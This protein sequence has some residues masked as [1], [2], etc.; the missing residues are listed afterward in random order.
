MILLIVYLIFCLKHKL[1]VTAWAFMPNHAHFLFR[2][3]SAG[4]FWQKIAGKE[5]FERGYELK[6]LGYDLKKISQMVSTIS[7]IETEEIYSK[8]RR[9]VQVEARELLCY[10][11]VR[12]L[13]ISCDVL[14]FLDIGCRLNIVMSI[15]T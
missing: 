15:I 14:N 2:T 6:E 11:A 13:G 3:G 9:K 4:I 8:G 12:E 1:H 7:D 10:W 5:K